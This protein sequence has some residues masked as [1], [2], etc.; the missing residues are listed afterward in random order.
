[1]GV[2]VLN[3]IQPECMDIYKLKDNFGDTLTF[4]GGISTQKTLPSGTPLEVK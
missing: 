3:P 2:D 4:W 1:M